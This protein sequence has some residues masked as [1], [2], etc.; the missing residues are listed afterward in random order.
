MLAMLVHHR[1]RPTRRPAEDLAGWIPVTDHLLLSSI[2]AF[3][4]SKQYWIYLKIK[5]H[6]HLP[7][8]Q[9]C[10]AIHPLIT[11]RGIRVDRRGSQEKTCCIAK[12]TK[13]RL[14]LGKPWSLR[15]AVHVYIVIRVLS[16][17]PLQLCW[18]ATPCH[19]ECGNLRQ[20]SLWFWAPCGW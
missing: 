5:D 8:L 6:E 12:I 16:W 13:I 3:L 7:D 11:A 18:N 4:H 20:S 15:Q 9:P 14:N 17:Y 19:P 1:D 10:E 2:L